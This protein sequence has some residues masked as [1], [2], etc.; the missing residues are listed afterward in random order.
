MSQFNRITM[1]CLPSRWWGAA[2][3]QAVTGA[4][5]VWVQFIGGRDPV[6][7]GGER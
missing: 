2:L 5:L 6:A 1:C 7:T 3:V 4:L